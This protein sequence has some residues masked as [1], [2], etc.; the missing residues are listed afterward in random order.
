MNM[1]GFTAEAALRTTHGRSYLVQKGVG[2]SN[3]RA[4]VLP[5]M[6]TDPFSPSTIRSFCSEMGGLY[7]GPGATTTTW[8][9][10]YN[11]GDSGIVCG[12]NEPDSCDTW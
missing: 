1:P 5:A 10:V 8:G 12:G 11:D 4:V 2:T 9:C 3:N 6:K 7:W